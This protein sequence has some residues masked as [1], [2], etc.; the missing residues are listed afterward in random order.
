MHPG[1]EKRALTLSVSLI[2]ADRLKAELRL[3]FIH[4]LAAALKTKIDMD[5]VEYERYDFRRFNF[6]TLPTAIHSST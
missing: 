6:T 4:L 3:D 1:G 2:K 5:K